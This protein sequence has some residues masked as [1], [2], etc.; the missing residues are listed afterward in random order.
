MQIS[1]L[2][3]IDNAKFESKVRERERERG[4]AA[5]LT[6]THSIAPSAGV[7]VSRLVNYREPATS[8][9]TAPTPPGCSCRFQSTRFSYQFPIRFHCFLSFSER[10]AVF[11]FARFLRL[12]VHCRLCISYLIFRICNILAA[13]AC[14]AMPKKHLRNAAPSGEICSAACCVLQVRVACVLYAQVEPTVAA[15]VCQVRVR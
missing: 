10:A 5:W 6:L 7:S 13:L 4:T 2:K 15:A 11:C 3:L 1:L 14:H 9:H 12:R 8:P